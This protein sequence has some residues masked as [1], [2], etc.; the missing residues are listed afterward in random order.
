MQGMTVRLDRIQGSSWAP[1]G[2]SP[3]SLLEGYKRVKD[4]FVRCQTS[5]P[6]Y[7]RRREYRS[8]TDGKSVF[9]QYQRR[10]GFLRPWKVNIYA[11]DRKGLSYE[12][13]AQILRFCHRWRFR[14]VEV[15]VDFAPPLGVNS[16]FVRKYAKFGKCKRRYDLEKHAKGMRYWGSRKGE[17]FVRC[18]DKHGLGI[19]R[20][21]VQ[22]NGGLLRGNGIFNLEHLVNLPDVVF[23]NHF[24]FVKVEWSGLRRFLVKKLGNDGRKLYVRSRNRFSSLARLRRQLKKHGVVNIHRFLVPLRINKY[25]RRALCEWA[26]RFRKELK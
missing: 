4:S 20:V 2:L 8:K 19:Y 16:E 15:A 18:Y 1:P 10:Q 5:K 7:A 9:W 3:P 25:T 13:V 21:E 14:S 24:Q 26:R 22:L 12:D 11:D 23:P 6:T 17:K